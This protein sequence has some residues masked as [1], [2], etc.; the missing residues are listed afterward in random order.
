MASKEEESKGSTSSEEPEYDSDIGSAKSV[1]SG[2]RAPPLKIVQYL[3]TSLIVSQN[4]TL[5]DIEVNSCPTNKIKQ[6][7]DQL[8]KSLKKIKIKPILID[9]KAEMKQQKAAGNTETHIEYE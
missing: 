4:L 3:S 7:E 2:S 1:A 9:P 5:A 6:L 8:I